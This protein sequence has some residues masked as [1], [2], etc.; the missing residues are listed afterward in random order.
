MIFQNTPSEHSSLLSARFGPSFAPTDRIV[1]S[2][3][4]PPER[5]LKLRRVAVRAR[6][7]FKGAHSECD[8]ASQS[9]WITPI[10]IRGWSGLEKV[11]RLRLVWMLRVGKLSLAQHRGDLRPHQ[12]V[13]AV[14]M[15]WRLRLVPGMSSMPAWPVIECE[16]LGVLLLAWRWWKLNIEQEDQVP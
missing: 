1:H 8:G 11:D 12:K 10:E 6:L 3:I 4:M 2:S 15:L 16:C 5:V 9:H 14:R 13:K 7:L